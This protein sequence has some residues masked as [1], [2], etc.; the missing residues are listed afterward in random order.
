MVTSSTEFAREVWKIPADTRAPPTRLLGPRGDPMWMFLARDGRTLLFNGTA[1]GS[2]NL[3]LG[4]L[5][6]LADTRQITFLPGDAVAHSSLAPDGT[7]VAFVS[8]ATG[9][10]D[11]SVQNVDGSDLRQLTN[12]AAADSWPVWSPDGRWLVYTSL[13]DGQQETW[14]IPT[15]KGTAEKI[16]DG[17]F[18]GDWQRQLSGNG[19]WILTSNGQDRV[20][21]LDAERR[22]VVWD[23]R[24]PNSSS[25]LPMFSP[26][27]RSFSLAS[28]AGRERDTINIFD[29]LTGEHRSAIELPFR[30]FFRAGWTN[31]SSA[32]IVNRNANA[33]HI[34][35][36]DGFWSPA[37]DRHGSPMSR[38]G[39]LLRRANDAVSAARYRRVAGT[40][41]QPVGDDARSLVTD[42]RIGP[43]L[44]HA[45]W[46]AR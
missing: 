12:D 35:L 6:N 30:V 14:R 2:R 34:V 44:G 41:R 46:H 32:F 40:G 29:T 1:S 7:R 20:R 11:V 25:G 27:G 36:F 18:R 13:R 4:A 19:T 31:Q 17:F 10:S 5:D 21:L 9:N 42:P 45:R 22:S 8:T 33:S 16:F 23:V 43:A 38:P 37:A 39:Q 26:D 15:T 3:W 28:Q 24:V